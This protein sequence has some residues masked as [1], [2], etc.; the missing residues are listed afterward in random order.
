M[1][2]LNP[3]C[4]RAEHLHVGFTALPL[5]PEKVGGGVVTTFNRFAQA[6]RLQDGVDQRQ[7]LLC[8]LGQC[9]AAEASQLCSGQAV[10]ADDESVPLWAVR[11]DALA[12]GEHLLIPRLRDQYIVV[13][14]PDLLISRNI[15]YRGCYR[16]PPCPPHSRIQLDPIEWRSRH[17]APDGGD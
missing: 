14:A 9:T 6:L 17:G 15:V 3:L 4:D 2:R 11:R 13:F 8:C 1:Q 12:Y 10:F 7:L 5:H 16:A